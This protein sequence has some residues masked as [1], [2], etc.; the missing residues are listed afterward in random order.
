M[1]GV[2]RAN[3]LLWPKEKHERHRWVHVKSVSGDPLFGDFFDEFGRRIIHNI[4]VA[5]R[6]KF[7]RE[8]SA[9]VEGL[10]AA[11]LYVTGDH[12]GIGS[13]VLRP[14]PSSPLL[15]INLPNTM[16]LPHVKRLR[17][18]LGWLHGMRP[19]DQLSVYCIATRRVTL[20]VVYGLWEDQKGRSVIFSHPSWSRVQLI[21]PEH[22][23]MIHQWQ[24]DDGIWSWRPDLVLN[25]PSIPEA[26]VASRGLW[27]L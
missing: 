19:D 15:H 3:D 11:R 9:I 25:D 26:P 5:N 23:V 22:Q 17:D 16:D 21:L 27:E 2:L 13:N 10:E 8:L 20:A 7:G 24:D 4:Y 18:L 6:T 1:D 14:L 12:Q